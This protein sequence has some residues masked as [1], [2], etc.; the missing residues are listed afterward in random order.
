[1]TLLASASYDPAGAVTKATTALLAMTAL[2]TTN[3]RLTFTAPPNGT[4]L[5]RLKSQTIGGVLNPRVQLGILDGATLR[6]R[7]NAVGGLTPPNST[8]SCGVE[9]SYLITGLTPGNSFTWDAAYGVDIVSA[10]SALKYG[11]PNDAAGGDASG[12]FIYEIWSTE[13]LLAGVFYDPLAAA[14]LSCTS[15]LAMT[16]MDTT[17]LRLA[18]TAPTSGNV[19]WRIATQ[20]HGANLANSGSVL[21]GIL[22]STTVVAR[23]TPTQQ[24]SSAVATSCF[25]SESTGVITGLSAGS[26]T[27]D[28]SYAVQTVATAGGFKHG[29]PNNTTTNDC[30]GGI[31]FEV[32]QA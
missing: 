15:L 26:H 16:A 12:A 25:A 7:A 23:S 28:A 6:G 13:N 1:M 31:A 21:L 9:S 32:W 20:Q 27:W 10:S 18:F 19:F 2:D 11:G 29:G 30:F 4:V 22:E 17:N 14:T 24:L 5:V 3:L 8:T